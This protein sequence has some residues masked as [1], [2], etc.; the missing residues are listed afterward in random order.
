MKIYSFR[1]FYTKMKRTFALFLAAFVLASG[2]TQSGK[3]YTI[4]GYA[5]GGTYHIV[6]DLPSASMLESL[7]GAVSDTLGA[8]DRSISGYNKGSLL[9]RFNNGEN[10]GL[11]AIF[12]DIFNRSYEIWEESGGMFDPSSAP[13]FDLWGFGFT[14]GREPS[15]EEVGA[16]LSLVGM[17][18]FS[19]E[20][21]PDGFVRLNAPEGAALN[22]NAIAQGYSC[23][24]V[25]EVLRRYGS[26]N[27]LVEI[28]GEIV[29]RG[30]NAKGK[31]WR[32]WIDKPVDGNN[33]SGAIKQDI[34]EI[35]DCG[36]VTSGNYRKFYV[37]DGEKYSHTIN[38]RTGRPVQHT[39]LSATVLAPDSATA[40]AYATWLMVVGVEE[41]ERVVE[42][43]AVEPK[44]AYLVYG[45]Q[46]AMKV[47]HTS[48]IKVSD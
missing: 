48:G 6:A 13:L 7:K 46:E 15:D 23:D 25:A 14:D 8:I 3:Y 27:Y 26:V 40:D 16:A 12:V 43:W 18:K 33:Q 22:F 47:W 24:A 36:L 17:D 35:T 28:G 30:L 5:Q 38:P 19:L 2:C 45:E 44:G 42:G 9:S 10:P 37:V 34:V 21:G 1:I 29:C 11:D 32:V 39:L 41:A 31:E 4:D 20:E